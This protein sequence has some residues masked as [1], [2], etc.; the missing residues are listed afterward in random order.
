MTKPVK[1]T[2][3]SPEDRFLK[4]ALIQLLEY[5]TGRAKLEKRLNKILEGNPT[6]QTIW[7]DMLGGL[8]IPLDINWEMVDRIPKNGPL[9]LIA[10]HPFGVVDGIAMAHI[11][12][13]IRPH[14]KA[15]VNEVLCREQTINSCFLPVDFRETK[16]AMEINISTRNK[17]ME[18][19]K[20]GGTIV[21]FPAGGVSTSPKI[22]K[23]AEDFEWKRFV[24]KLIEKTEATVVPIYFQGQNSHL[25]QIASLIHLNLRYGLLLNEVKNKM[26]KTLKAVIGEPIDKDLQKSLSRNDI[27]PF[28]RERVYSLAR[29]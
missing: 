26:G 17:A 8:N 14:F 16:E 13:Q 23:K 24:V 29:N 6:E 20:Q 11:A 1:I 19:L 18:Y 5:A 15:L 28:L 7:G 2:Y 10:N 9:I 4:S 12:T 27:L 21:I 22:F 3:S 25:F